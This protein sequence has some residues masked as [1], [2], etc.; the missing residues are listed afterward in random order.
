MPDTIRKWD[1]AGISCKWQGGEK[2]REESEKIF[3]LTALKYMANIL[4]SVS[5]NLGRFLEED[6]L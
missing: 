5:W 3:E 4:E 1:S 6:I 2:V